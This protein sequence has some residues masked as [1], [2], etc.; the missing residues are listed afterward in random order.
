[1]NIEQI[2]K[3]VHIA[4]LPAAGDNPE[5]KETNISW[6]ILYDDVAYKIKR[7]VKY[8]F[9]DFSTLEN[10]RHYCNQEVMLNRRLAPQMYMGVIT[11]SPPM[12]GDPV[13]DRTDQTVDYAVQMR[14]MNNK[15]EMH[16][17]LADNQVTDQQIIK[18]AEKIAD[19]HNKIEVIKKDFDIDAFQNLYADIESMVPFTKER[20]GH[21]WANK[22]HVCLEKSDHFLKSHSELLAERVNQGFIKNC[23]GDLNSFNIF[24]YDDP[25]IFDCLE[26]NEDFRHIDVIN[27]MAFLCVDL[28][29]F[30]KPDLSDLFFEKYLERA[31]T[32]DEASTHK[33]FNYYKSYR[34]NI[35]AKV[36]LLSAQNHKADKDSEEINDAKKYI[37][38]ME[39]YIGE[40]VE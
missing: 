25:V 6:V 26:F 34:A 23:H 33:L 30:D 8:S 5:I 13:T 9:V 3:L 39:E 31:A 17:L 37:E 29:F 10:R 24:L 21:K 14:R 28:D 22:I 20:A 18:L 38:L 7:P 12:T 15:L 27:D 11:I 40:V 35:R 4:Q 1:M 2:H 19:F 16:Q 36:T 32:P